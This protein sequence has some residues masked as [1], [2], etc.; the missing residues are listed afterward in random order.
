[1]WMKHGFGELESKD[2]VTLQMTLICTKYNKR[3]KIL[4]MYTH[5]YIEIS[6]SEGKLNYFMMQAQKKAM[7]LA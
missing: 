5:T 4:N 3:K 6:K 2:M 7:F 1:M